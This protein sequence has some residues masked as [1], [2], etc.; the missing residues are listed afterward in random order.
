MWEEG[1]EQKTFVKDARKGRKVGHKDRSR[2]SK[3][4][5]MERR[6]RTSGGGKRDKK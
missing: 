6:V 2:M 5:E 1:T 3:S 4:K